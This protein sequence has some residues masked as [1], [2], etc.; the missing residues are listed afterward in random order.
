V[1]K[2]DAP[3]KAGVAENKRAFRLVQHKVVVFLRLKS[4]RFDP[5]FP[6]HAQ[7]K[8]D[9]ITAGKLEEHLFS[10]RF[11]TQKTFPGYFPDEFSRIRAAEDAFRLANLQAQD[12]LAEARVPLPAIEFHF[13]QLR[14]GTI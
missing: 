5:Q 11:R 6:G 8:T 10:P 3:E 7:M 4:R 14:H 12:F 9:P 13:G 2:S 1:V